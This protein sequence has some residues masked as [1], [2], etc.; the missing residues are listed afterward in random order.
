MLYDYRIKHAFDNDVFRIRMFMNIPSLDYHLK[1]GMKFIGYNKS[2][3]PFVYLPLLK[4]N[5][6]LDLGK[7]YERLGLK[8]CVNAVKP[9]ID[10]QMD[11]IIAKGGRWINTEEEQKYWN[12]LKK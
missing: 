7:N 10:K 4:A 11:R 9:E 3:M 2:G 8:W 6:V 1:C 12:Y 5:S